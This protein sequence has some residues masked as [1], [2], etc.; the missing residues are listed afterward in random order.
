VTRGETGGEVLRG[1]VNTVVRVGD[2]VRRPVGPW[3]PAV[4]ALLRHVAAAGFAGAPRVHGVGQ[5]GRE[6]LDFV[7]GEVALDAPDTDEAVAAAGGLLRAY[8]D[9]TAGFVA[10]P[11]ARWYLPPRKPAEVICHGDAATYNCVFRDGLPVAWIDF[12]TAHPGPRVWDAAYTAYRFVPLSAG[13]D[14]RAQAARLR[15]F[16]DGY[17]P[18]LG[19]P[20]RVLAVAAERLRA[21]VAHMRRRAAA[22]DEAFRGHLAAGHGRL[23]LADTA[24]IE[25]NAAAIADSMPA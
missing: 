18:G 24:H 19:G 8:H 15:V 2:T 10:P 11:G 16:L 25:G 23:Y 22:G 5:D 7:P 9:A 12:D 14:V 21:L 20:A 17:G 13:G 4:H 6:I 1:G 3:T